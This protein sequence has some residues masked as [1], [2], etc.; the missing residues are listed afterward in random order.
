V[1]APD[2]L[3]ARARLEPQHGK[4]LFFAHAAGGA[5]RRSPRCTFLL[6]LTPAWQPEIEI[7]FKQRSSLGI[8]GTDFAEEVEKL[9]VRQ[10]RQGTPGE[11]AL[12]AAS[13]ESAAVMV[14]L[15][16]KPIGADGGFLTRRF[17]RAAVRRTPAEQGT[18]RNAEQSEAEG[19][20]R[21]GN[22]NGAAEREEDGEA[23]KDGAADFMQHGREPL[24]IGSR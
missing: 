15:H 21:D 16:I 19:H 6:A 24:R 20:K 14:E 7:G 18:H 10:R 4:R 9:S 17:S 3:F 2:L 12:E 23:D 22:R 11:A 1:S 8:A 5:S 13:I